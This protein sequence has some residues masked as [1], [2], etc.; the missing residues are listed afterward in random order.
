MEIKYLIPYP[1][2]VTIFSLLTIGTITLIICRKKINWYKYTHSIL[3]SFIL[4]VAEI[5]N[6]ENDGNVE[7]W[8]FPDGSALLGIA[9]GKVYWED[10][11]FVPACVSIFYVFM[12]SIRNVKD[13]LPKW[14]YSY[15]ICTAVII[16]AMIYQVGGK[17]IENLMVGYTLVPL[18][19][20][21]VYCIIK[22]P[23]LNITH[24]VI[25][26]FFVAIFSMSWELI[27]MWRQHWIYNTHC[28]LMG[29]RGWIFNGKLHVGIFLQYAYSGFVIVYGSWISF[30][31]KNTQ[32]R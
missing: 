12:W 3:F 9:W 25:T 2:T 6:L 24:M 26:L 28:D 16:E 32:L 17:G 20:V 1:Y 7:S 13:T 19:V 4:G 21:V 30:D 29:D 11:L 27:N 23:K 10:I 31:R 18:L 15:L 8:F 14:S 22:K 5:H